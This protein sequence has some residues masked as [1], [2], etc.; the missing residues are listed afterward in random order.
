MKAIIMA[1]GEGTRLRPLTCDCPKPMMRLMD[2]P[3]MD[4]SLE[5]L[6][7]HGVNEAAVTL[8]YLPE[9]I[10]DWFGDERHGVRLKY[11]TERQPLGTAGGVKQAA[12]FLSETFC[13]L[14]GDGVTDCDLSAALK[15][16][17]EKGA[18]ATM[19]LKRMPDPT[20]YGLVITELDGRVSRFLEKPAWGE[21]VSDAVNTGIYILEPEILSLIPEGAYD[22]GKQLFPRLAAEGILYGWITDSY[23]CDVGDISAYL[24]MCRDALDGRIALDSLKIDGAVIAPG[25]HVSQEAEL[26]PPCYIGPGARVERGAVVGAH[27]IVGTGVRIGEFAS[28]KRSVVWHGA[29]IMEG[30]QL[31]GCAV[32]RDATLNPCARV[33]ENCALGTGAVIGADAE[34][35]PG[36]C[37]WPGKAVAEATLLDSNLVWGGISVSCFRDGRLPVQLPSDALRCAQAC[38]AALKPRELLLGRAPS[39]IASA[40]W[41]SCAAGLMAQGVRVLDAGVCTEPQ[42]RYAMELVG[43]DCALMALDDGVLPLEKGGVRISH[44][45]QRSVCA[46]MSRQDYPRPFTADAQPVVYSGRSE[47]AYIA[48]LAAA[49]CADPSLSPPVAVHSENPLL[50]TLAE[51]AFCRAG[52][53]AR[54]EWEAELMELFPGEVGVWLAP[55]GMSARFSHADGMLTAPQNELMQAWTALERGESILMLGDRATR[56]IAD[57]AGR[58][59]AE[60]R[61]VGS[62]RPALEKALAGFPNQLRL[63]TD[64]VYFAL[65]AISALTENALTLSGWVSTMPRVH[66]IEK[67]VHIDDSLRG[68]ALRRLTENSPRADVSSGLTI[69]RDGAFAWIAP[70]GDRPECAI[71]TEAWDIEAARELCDFCEFQLKK[72]A[73]EK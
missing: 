36:V 42:L 40:V 3:I 25:A 64:G 22:F 47:Q 2:R 62:S 46:L 31:R 4:Y 39:A 21:V 33:Y 38:A 53:S 69:D 59:G 17:R 14:S 66:R 37:V 11:Y 7:R 24:G 12:D 50:L 43:A 23:W 54:F 49:F 30:A 72:A 41:H 55:D 71:V 5:L 15:F 35:A 10:R 20:A 51:Q 45:S 52:L 16:H 28:L 34:V 65:C 29:Q 19:V 63:A 9:R 56:S 68:R 13:V 58:Y 27:S 26:H 6:S 8:G 61:R 32:G 70:D 1:G 48:M 60:V 67:R 57:V 73:E 18:R 44:D